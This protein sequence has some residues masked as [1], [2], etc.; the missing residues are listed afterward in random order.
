MT[1]I[2]ANMAKIVFDHTIQ[3]FPEAYTKPPTQPLTKK[4]GQLTNEQI[5]HFFTEGFV[6]IEDFLDKN[7]LNEVKLE[8]ENQVDTLANKL[9]EA[10]KI[11]N[12]HQDKDFY[13]RSIYLNRE[14]PGVSVI[15][16]K[17]DNLGPAIKKLWSNE[18]L[19]DAV[20]QIIGPNI[21]AHPG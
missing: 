2:S 11:Q 19:L 1:K 3:A 7:L 17:S 9:F 5:N 10:G 14:F 20:E 21:A 6:I 13:T 18:K 8:L 4:I 16:H 15:H 12:L